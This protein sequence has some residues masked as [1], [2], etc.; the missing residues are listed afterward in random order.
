MKG[1]NNCLSDI[2]QNILSSNV[3]K[4][5]DSSYYSLK[6]RYSSRSEYNDNSRGVTGSNP[7]HSEYVCPDDPYLRKSWSKRATRLRLTTSS[8][9]P[10]SCCTYKLIHRKNMSASLFDEITKMAKLYYLSKIQMLFFQSGQQKIQT[11]SAPYW[12]DIRYA[13]FRIRSDKTFILSVN[14]LHIRTELAIICATTEL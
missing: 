8:H 4:Q 2:V 1:N 11:L 13:S 7:G 14:V 3:M 12:R 10:H 9:S 6:T 5:R